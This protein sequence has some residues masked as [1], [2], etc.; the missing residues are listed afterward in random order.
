MQHG[1]DADSG[2]EVLRIGGDGDERLGRGLEQDVVDDGLVLVG[3]VADRGWQRE[4]HVV[5]GH[6]QQ[7]GLAV[8]KPFLCC[9]ALALGAMP[10]A[11]GVIGDVRVRALLA[12]RDMPAESRRAAGLDGRHHLEL[13]EAHMA[14]VGSAPGRPVGAEDVRDLQCRRGQERRFTRAASSSRRDAR[15]GS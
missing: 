12:A 2:T 15:A 10:I 9:R 7:L 11:A 6:G 8:G 4:D 1:G 3:D 14:G 13:A 5:V